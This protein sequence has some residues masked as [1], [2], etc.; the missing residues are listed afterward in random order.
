MF[1]FLAARA[2]FA[3]TESVSS[4]AQLAFPL[5][6]QGFSS[7]AIAMGSAFVAV[8]G[9]VS[10]I[11]W[12]PAGLAALSSPQLELD[13]N[14]Y[15]LDLMQDTVLFAT[16]QGSF[17]SWGLSASY[18]SYGSLQGRDVNGDVT[19]SY[20]AGRWG[21]EILWSHSLFSGFAIGLGLKGNL[22]NL[23]GTT[24]SN[25]A[26]DAGILWDITRSLHVGAS[27]ANWGTD[28]GGYVANSVI[29]AGGA[30]DLALSPDNKALLA[31][32]FSLEPFGVAH[33]DIGAED[34]IGSLLAFR[35]GYVVDFSPTDL[36]GL[37]GLTAGLGLGLQDFNLD[38]AYAPF[39]D[40]G[41]SQR[42]SLTYHFEG[43]APQATPVSLPKAS[44][45]TAT[46]VAG[47]LSPNTQ[48]VT[49][50]ATP[51]TTIVPVPTLVSTPP[52]TDKLK[53]FFSLSGSQ[54]VST[55]TQDQGLDQKALA[56]KD[57]IAANPQD[58]KS[59]YGLGSLYYQNNHKDEAIQCFE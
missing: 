48:P 19:G 59:W 26:G 43:E 52:P 47:L 49:V 24:Y 50:F 42:V 51:V 13:H 5:D 1:F 20:S 14:F 9:D 35:A 32:G 11:S 56:F 33:V 40:L 34:R 58:V 6:N 41:S 29:Q 28:V 4:N 12:N 57:A 22:L 53:L 7:R 25:I 27:Y 39:G 38:Y 3:A 55:Q 18:L 36:Q 23:S 37:T 2:G 31:G 8:G 16:P 17:G 54:P 10:S 30:Y 21:G 15:L 46:P 44:L 45:K